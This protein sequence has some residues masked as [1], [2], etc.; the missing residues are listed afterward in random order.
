MNIE[1]QTLVQNKNI[2]YNIMSYLKFKEGYK[3]CITTNCFFENIFKVF[4]HQ[5]IIKIKLEKYPLTKI[6][7]NIKFG[8]NL[9][10]MNIK[11]VSILSNLYEL[12]LPWCENI[13]DVSMLC[14]VHTLDLSNCDG[15][16]DVSALGNVYELN[17]PTAR[18]D[19]IPIGSMVEKVSAVFKKSKPNFIFTR[20][21]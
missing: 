14:N 15:I 12:Y 13:T 10:Y 8:M 17:F 3:L 9:L 2:I 5:E 1:Q 18:L 19:R 11:D 7:K 16:T 20:V 4:K 6:W 21:T